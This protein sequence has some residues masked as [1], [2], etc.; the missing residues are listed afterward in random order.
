[1]Y[2]NSDEILA[3]YLAKNPEAKAEWDEF[4]KLHDFDPRGDKSRQ[5]NA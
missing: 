2:M 4:Q 5:D 1:M 3:D